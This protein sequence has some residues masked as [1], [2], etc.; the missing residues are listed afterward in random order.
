MY[1]KKTSIP[2]ISLIYM[3]DFRSTV[4]FSLC[5]TSMPC[6]LS[7]YLHQWHDWEIVQGGREGGREGKGRKGGYYHIMRGHVAGGEGVN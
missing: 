4:L 1:V 5:W 6:W 7:F 2:F 3:L